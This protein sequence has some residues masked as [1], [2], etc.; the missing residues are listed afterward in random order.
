[1]AWIDDRIWCHPKLAG[2]TAR[3]F[4]A[5][6]HGLAYSSGFS[7]HGYLTA[8]QIKTIGADAASRR[9]LVKAGLWEQGEHGILIHDWNEHNGRRDAKRA[10]DRERKRRQRERDMTRD[11]PRDVTRDTDRDT[12]RDRRALTDE[13][14]EG[15]DGKEETVTP[16]VLEYAA[17][18]PDDG[19]GHGGLTDTEI[20]QLAADLL[21]EMPA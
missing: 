14:S 3:A 11:T 17:R 18:E 2:L 10:A 13:G 16:T 8:A 7:T 20:D 12:P 19:H 4:R 15:S 21:H 6:V 5:Y 9:E 1:M